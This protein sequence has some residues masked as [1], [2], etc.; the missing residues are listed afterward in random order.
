MRP[1]HVL[2]R[3]F[4]SSSPPA[5][6]IPRL[7]LYTGGPACTLCTDLKEELL[8]L[9]RAPASNS[10]SSSSLDSGRTSSVKQFDLETYDIRKTEADGP[11]EAAERKQWRRLYKYDIPVLHLVRPSL[12]KKKAVDEDPVSLPGVPPIADEIEIFRHRLNLS[13]LE[14]A[15]AEERTRLERLLSTQASP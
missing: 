7:K 11:S 4:L 10:A 2:Y 6:V 8:V 13:K 9:Q 5:S 3:R 14:T 15:L 1:S 12:T